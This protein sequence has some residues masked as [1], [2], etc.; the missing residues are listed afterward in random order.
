MAKDKATPSKHSSRE[1]I[2]ELLAGIQADLGST[3]VML[4]RGRE[5]EGRFDLRRPCGIPA[6]D[7]ATGGGL[8]AGGLSQIDG[9]EGTGKNLLIYHYFAKVQKLYKE[10]TRIFMLCMEFPFD[11]MFAYKVGFRVPFSDYEIGVEQRGRKER[12]E[13][14]LTKKEV[15]ALQ[16]DTDTGVFV[17]PRGGSAEG[18]LEAVVQLI[19]SN[20]FQ[21]GAIDSWDSM[22]TAPEEE[23]PLG[24][25][26][27]IASPAS[28]QTR[29]M[30]KVQGALAPKKLCHECRSLDIEFKKTANGGWGYY[31]SDK[32]CGWKGRDPFLEENETTI[33]GIRQV[34]ANLHKM[35]MHSRDWKVGGSHALKHGKLVDI[36]LRPGEQLKDKDGTRIGKEIVWEITK[37]KAGTHEGKTGS[38]KYYFEPP[39]VDVDLDFF[40][41][42]LANGIITKA[43]TSIYA[44]DLQNLSD[45]Q[46]KFK[47]QGEVL[48]ALADDPELKNMLWRLMLRQANLAHIRNRTL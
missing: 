48:E 28:V 32:N 10:N 11:K 42:C 8:P 37:G 47:G 31:C 17:I 13:E 38:F 6:L 36:Q 27:R 1:D 34:R 40:G 39:E 29:W 44:I 14:P 12:G 21:L 2:D 41:Y 22:L 30:K 15:E 46:Y 43:G 16:D 5:L 23:T 3:G 9:P 24:E 45:K 19:S 18:N 33:I 4:Q 26:P 35:G 7:I 25:D 20:K